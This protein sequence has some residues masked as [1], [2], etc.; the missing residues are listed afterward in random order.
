MERVNLLIPDYKI[1]V[2]LNGMHLQMTLN[3]TQT[4]KFVF[5]R[6]ENLVGKGEIAGYQYFLLFQ[7]CFQKVFSSGLKSHHRTGMVK[8]FVNSECSY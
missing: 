7:Q 6:E 4:I 3:V 8:Y 2:L 5:H 1:V